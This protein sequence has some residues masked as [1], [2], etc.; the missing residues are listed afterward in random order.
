MIMHL[1][2]TSRPNRLDT[3]VALTASLLFGYSSPIHA[4]GTNSGSF[5]LPALEAKDFPK[6]VIGTITSVQEVGSEFQIEIDNGF[7]QRITYQTSNDVQITHGIEDGWAH[8]LS[9]GD[10]VTLCLE[11]QPSLVP[12]LPSR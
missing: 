8:D 11:N 12:A 6:T 10:T 4:R 3:A 1:A 9:V 2:P 5:S 7:G